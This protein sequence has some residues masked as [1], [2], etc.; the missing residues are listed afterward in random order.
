ME[1]RDTP[2]DGRRAR[3]RSD[4]VAAVAGL[5]VLGSGMLAV[6]HGTVSDP[7][8]SVFELVNDLPEALYP[9]LWPFQQLGALLA[10]PV[11]ALVA[12]IMRRYRLALAAVLATVAKLGTERL[13]K[14]MVSRQRP[15]TSVGPDIHVRGD[16][17]VIGESFVSG[18]AVLIAALAT[19]ITPY[20]H[21]RWR[22]V[23]SV[24]VAL[25]L[26]GR[27]YV[28]AHLPLDVLC[29]AGL[30]LAVGSVLNLLLGVPAEGGAPRA[31]QHAR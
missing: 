10:G 12:V 27:V 14:A 28:G 18:H 20:L 24:V 23:P 3:R 2:A 19:I 11:V 7:E 22:L 30:G 9:V 8:E 16:V 17:S 29:G 4:V 1:G 13:V 26:V 25:V 15:G 21:G 31:G 6:R 5:A